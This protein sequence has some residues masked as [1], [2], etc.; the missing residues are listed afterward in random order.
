MCRE[1][2]GLGECGVEDSGPPAMRSCSMVRG[3]VVSFDL[4]GHHIGLVKPHGWYQQV[5]QLRQ[6]SQ[7]FPLRD[8]I[9]N[10]FGFAGHMVSIVYSLLFVFCCFVVVVVFFIAL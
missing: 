6:E 9:V 2:G 5:L 10:I 4:V 8:Q 7:T 1:V 3:F